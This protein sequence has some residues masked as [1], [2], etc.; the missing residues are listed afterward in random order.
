MDQIEK[1]TYY[2][3]VMMLHFTISLA[4]GKVHQERCI[5]S[6]ITRHTLTGAVHTSFRSYWWELS[7]S[8]KSS[9]ITLLFR[10]Q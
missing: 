3:I 8:L 6:S 1:Q 5:L 9:L 10:T 4:E 2:V 7:I